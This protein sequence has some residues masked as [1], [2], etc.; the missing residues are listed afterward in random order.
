[1]DQIVKTTKS[2]KRIL[3]IEEEMIDKEEVISEPQDRSYKHREK[4]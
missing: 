2:V 1:M 4:L 3:G